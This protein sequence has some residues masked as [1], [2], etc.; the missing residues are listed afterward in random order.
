M[1]EASGTRGAKR[2][3]M[4]QNISIPTSGGR[5]FDAVLAMPPSGPAPALIFIPSIFGNTEGLQATIDRYATHGYIA[6]SIDPFWRTAPGPLGLDRYP[7]AS[8]R[9]NDWS[10]DE[11]LDDTRAAL[12][13]LKTIPSWNGKFAMVGF[14]F[15]GRLAMLGLMRLGADAAVTFHGTAMHLDL[16]EAGNIRGPFS[17]HFGEADPVVPMEQV[18]QVKAALAGRDGEIHVYAGAGHSFA[19]QESPRY[20]PE[21]GPLSEER[22]LKLLERLK[23]P[24]TA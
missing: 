1:S 2:S 14:C 18:D 12:A 5:S 3:I 15:G 19:Q 10:V 4:A 23:S 11:G 21:A 16:A 7:E 17:F 9:M 6:V 24:I 13:Y 20:H 22:A 8:K